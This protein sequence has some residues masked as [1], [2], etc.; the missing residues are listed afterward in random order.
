MR[1]VRKL[2][3]RDRVSQPH[4]TAPPRIV[5]SITA[6]Q[7]LDQTFGS[8]WKPLYP[9][10]ELAV[11]LTTVLGHGWKRA[12]LYNKKKEWIQDV[13]YIKNGKNTVYFIEN[14]VQWYL[15]KSC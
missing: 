11:M 9:L 15:D 8:S 14:I 7:L 3:V 1:Q 2:I 13:H 12:T 10:E 5:G 4:T 6:K